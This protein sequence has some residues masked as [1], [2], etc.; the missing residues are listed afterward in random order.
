MTF[1]MFKKTVTASI[2][3][4]L[5][6]GTVSSGALAFSDLKDVKQADKIL[7]LRDRGVV[8]GYDQDT[9][10]PHEKMTAQEAIPLIVKSLELSLAK[11]TF[12]K[13][14]LASD[15]FT[16]IDDDAWYAEA[17]VIAQLNGIPLDTDVNPNEPVTREQFV[18]WLMSGVFAT[19]EYAFIGIFLMVGDEKQVSDGYMNAIQKALIAKIAELDADDNFRPQQP[20][21]RAEAAVMARNAIQYV[22]EH[23]ALEPT[24]IEDPIE[25][26]E[27]TTVVKEVY[28]GVRQA[29]LSW[30]EK[31]HAGWSIQIEGIDFVSDTE[32]VVRYSLQ[33][34]DPAAL[35]AQVITEPTASTYLDSAYTDVSF[36]LVGT[37]DVAPIPPEEDSDAPVSSESEAQ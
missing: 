20:I 9:F 35:Y 17:F 25:S 8:S 3:A 33:Y 26:G 21:T 28:E 15:Y 18:Q 27:I 23:Q 1:F 10:A 2:A 22:E 32:A 5:L 31:P 11:F 36:V 13:Q 34:P 37:S 7:E 6:V 12:A 4:A 29:T 14:P 19:G 16:T 24:P 30:G